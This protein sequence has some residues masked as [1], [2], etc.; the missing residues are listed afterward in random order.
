MVYYAYRNEVKKVMK[1][2]EY[3]LAC[4]VEKLKK[5]KNWEIKIKT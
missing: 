1:E 5:I 3:K 2:K 4:E